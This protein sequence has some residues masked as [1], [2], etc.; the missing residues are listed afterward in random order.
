[1]TSRE[2]RCFAR[3][4]QAYEVDYY[5]QQ[6]YM[7]LR[8]GLWPAEATKRAEFGYKVLRADLSADTS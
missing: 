6:L 3:R 7:F 4:V 2:A 1:L 5:V 8:T